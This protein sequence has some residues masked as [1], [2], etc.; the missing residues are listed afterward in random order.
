MSSFVSQG[1][2]SISDYAIT[3]HYV[4]PKV[5]QELEFYI[6]HLAPYGIVHGLQ[7]INRP[8]PRQANTT[9]TDIPDTGSS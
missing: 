4:T 5:M 7:D 2:D 3:F 8:P 6:Y 1:A 9:K